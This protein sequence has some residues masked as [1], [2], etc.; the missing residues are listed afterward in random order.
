M[1]GLPG[2]FG[3]LSQEGMMSQD[4]E[5]GKPVEAA[6][7]VRTVR[8]RL[9]LAHDATASTCDPLAFAVEAAL[10]NADVNDASS[11]DDARAALE[12]SDFHVCL[13]CLDLPPVPHGGVRLAQ[14][15]LA[16]GIPVVLVT[17]SQR[18]I[19]PNA[20]ALRALPWIAPDASTA[21]IGQAITTAMATFPHEA[22][23]LGESPD[24]ERIAG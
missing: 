5:L 3:K 11:V 13:V 2:S 7:G 15:I 9:L 22:V 17:R 24:P 6:S 16:L 20:S 19:P 18:W 1:P 8:W 14:E 12:S 4:H 23:A 10:G 21:E